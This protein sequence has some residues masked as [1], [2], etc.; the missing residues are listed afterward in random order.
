MPLVRDFRNFRFDM[1]RLAFCGKHLGRH[2]YWKLYTIEN[3]LRLTIH[4]I[5]YDQISPEWWD[6]AVDPAVRKNARNFR[7]YYARRVLHTP[8]GNHDIYYVFLSDLNNILRANS[9][10]FLPIVPDVDR[11]IGQIE[12]VRLRRNTVGHMNFLNRADRQIVDTVFRDFTSLVTKLQR[13]GHPI[14]IP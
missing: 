3:L 4:S 7:R 11:L 2:V 8:P 14:R 12:V 13:A 10:L 6:I 1:D 5:L 9:N